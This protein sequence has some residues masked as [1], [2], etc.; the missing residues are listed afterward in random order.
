MKI[1]KEDIVVDYTTESF[2]PIFKWISEKLNTIPESEDESIPEWIRE[3]ESYKKGL[4]TFDAASKVLILRFSYYMGE[5]FVRNYDS[6]SWSVGRRKTAVQNM[7]VV[8]GFKSK[9]E[10]APMLVCE[11]MFGTAFEEK[12]FE[13]V[14]VAI[15]TWI[16]FVE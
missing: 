5:C 12:S 15:H 2:L 7:P 1:E 3:T 9:M 13:R 8:T 4:Y 6:L 16:S 14:Q 11:N 10:L